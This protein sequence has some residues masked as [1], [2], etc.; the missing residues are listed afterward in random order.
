MPRYFTPSG[1]S[2]FVEDEVPEDELEGLF[3]EIDPIDPGTVQEEIE[4]SEPEPG[5]EEIPVAIPKPVVQPPLRRAWDAI[6]T[7]MVEMGDAEEYHPGLNTSESDAKWGG[8]FSGIKQG[9]LDTIESFT[10]PLNA[11]SLLLGGGSLG[12]A[13][14]GLTG[15]ARGLN[16]AAKAPEALTAI[17]GASEVFG[18]DKTLGE[19]A[20]G[21]VE[22]LGGGAGVM[23]KVPKPIPKPPTASVATAIPNEVLANANRVL[24]RNG[25]SAQTLG[26]SPEDAVAFAE[27]LSQGAPLPTPTSSVS[28]PR[29]TAL[30]TELAG[31][32]PRYNIGTK[33]YEPQFD[34]DIDKALFIISQGKPSKRDADYLK[35]VM[36][37]TGLDEG[38][39]RQAGQQLRNQMKGHIAGQEVGPVKLPKMFT[40]SEAPKP[41]KPKLKMIG[42]QPDMNDPVTAEWVNKAR[43]NK[44]TP[45]AQRISPAEEVD[46]P[47]EVETLAP[48][49]TPLGNGVM[50]KVIKEEPTALQNFFGLPRALQSTYDLSYP[51][52]QGLG[53]IHT[54]GWW[55]SWGKMLKS[56]G[57]EASYQG[58]MDSISERPNFK[59]RTILKNGVPTP[60]KSLAQEAGLAITDLKGMREEELSSSWAEK[61]PGVRASSRAYN[62]FAN[63][64]RADTF[65]D[66]VSKAKNMGMDP[67]AN[68]PLAKEIAA[69]VNNASGRGDLGSLSKAADAMNNVLFSPRLMASRV[70]MM[71]PANY[72]FRNKMVRKEYLKSMLATAGA[73]ATM[74]GMAKSAGAEVSMD[75]TNS[76]FGKIKIGDTRLDPAGGFQQYIVLATRLA[77][78]EFTSS[79]SGKTTQYGEKFGS[80][81]RMDALV[82]FVQN[83]L[84]PV[85]SYAARALN[86]NSKIPFYVGDE[87]TKLFVPILVQD[88]YELMN[89][90]PD[91]LGLAVPANLVGIGSNT[92]GKGPQTRMFPDSWE[93][94]IPAKRRR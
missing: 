36:D 75:P 60:G 13:K 58:L 9:A 88:I 80:P 42:N 15:A 93:M 55:T 5:P 85:P 92:Y 34:N 40:V 18:G 2:I 20:I 89:E 1:K 10:S 26:L 54:K 44:P 38:K 32:K 81:T 61:L 70:Q 49:G 31:A 82:D 78:G 74:A 14:A 69:F 53:L 25:Y 4:A 68:L 64:L 19:R 73:W 67:E 23:S 84:A 62:A 76:D 59:P 11:A 48:D 7:P 63:K 6:N 35:F 8:F 77:K 91:A 94:Q 45:Q 65:D 79:T 12:A 28:V 22:L 56:F 52:R 47:E 86:A 33:S 83:K 41:Q 3:D 90:N 21:A 39:A 43:S 37:A 46:I 51:F 71:N 87:T 17:H 30:P 27:K 57:S 29:P 50:G 16:I 66:L 24:Q 72:M